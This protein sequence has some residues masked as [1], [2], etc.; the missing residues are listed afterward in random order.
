[1]HGC[2][3]DVEEVFEDGSAPDEALLPGEDPF[4]EKRF[5]AIS[6]GAGEKHVVG[7]DDIEGAC[8]GS[9]ICGCAVGRGGVGTFGEACHDA[10]VV[11]VRMMVGGVVV[12]FSQ[13]CFVVVTGKA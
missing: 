3:V 13:S 2:S 10:V 6:S 5:P 8:V 11:V 9:I 12:S 4:I 1:M 7:V